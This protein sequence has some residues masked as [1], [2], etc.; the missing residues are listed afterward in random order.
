MLKQIQKWLR[1][2]PCKSVARQACGTECLSGAS[3]K[4]I[5]RAVEDTQVRQKSSE[6]KHLSCL[7]FQITIHL[8]LLIQNGPVRIVKL[9]L[10]PHLL[11]KPNLNDI[12][13]LPDPSATFELFDRVVIVRDQYPVPLGLKGTIIS[14][15]PRFDPNPVR[16]ENINAIDHIYE[17]LFDQPFEL[18][19]SIPDIAEKCVFRVRK[20]V[21]INITHGAGKFKL[22]E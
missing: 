13:V 1:E 7:N 15:L 22:H 21:L 20:S 17:V 4:Q 10:K 18:G 9:Q 14:I 11:Y 16:Q 6:R 12:N 5:V 19:T 2:I 3:I 8:L